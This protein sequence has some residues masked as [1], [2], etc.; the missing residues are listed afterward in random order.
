MVARKGDNVNGDSQVVYVTDP[1]N[2]NRM[3]RMGMLATVAGDKEVLRDRHVAIC[4]NGDHDYAAG[5][6]RGLMPLARTIKILEF[7]GADGVDEWLGADGLASDLQQLYD[8]TAEIRATP[9]ERDRARNELCPI[10]AS[11]LGCGEQ[12]DW[13]WFGFL[14]RQYITLLVGLWK[15]GKT[16]LISYMLQATAR[17]GNLA[18]DVRPAKVLVISEEGANLW[19]RRRDEVGI[20]DNANFVIRPFK[21]RPSYPEW[22]RSIE[23]LAE[24]V[25]QQRFDA[26]IFD[27]WQSMSPCM[28]ENDAAGTMGA[29][30]PLNAI[31]EAGAGVLLIHH[32]KKGDAGEGQA[33][34]GSGALPGFVDTIVELRRF[35][36]QDANDRRRKLRGHSRFDETPA[37]VVIELKDDGYRTIGS[38]SD[39]NRGDRRQV[40]QEILTGAD[41]M[42]VDEVR[43]NWPDTVPV[44]GKS[45]LRIDLNGGF[46]EGVWQRDGTG[47]K[48]SPYRYKFDS[49][50]EPPLGAQNANGDD[51][52][53]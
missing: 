46:N 48:G 52:P 36:P 29:L 9:K 39:A 53:F 22:N 32:P 38:T 8:E 17:G 18:G 25:R 1:P 33:S 44:P 11:Q 37:E 14:A 4:A 30:M 43:G 45:T 28:D 23:N 47:T 2:V 49:R 34:R 7:P 26:V 20:E 10:P 5:L 19:A 6:A 16:T 31:T 51:A 42:D 40:L 3:Q 35:N 13:L 41:W 21:R 27:T 15:A 12:V 50:T 24:T